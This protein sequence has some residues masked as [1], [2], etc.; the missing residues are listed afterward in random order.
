MIKAVFFDM[1]ETLLN[2]NL[3]QKKFEQYFKDDFALKYWFIKLLHTSTVT[4]I[5][6]EY[7]NF[8]VLADIVLENVFCE[9]GI[10]LSD[11]AKSEIL[12]SFR[13]LNTYGDVP[14]ALRKLRENQIKVITVSNSSLEMMKEQLTNAGILDLVDSYYS[15]DAVS[16]YKPFRDIYEF[17]ANEEKLLV[18]EVV[19]VATHDWDLF[20][21]K[22]SGLT[23]AYIKRKNVIYNPFYAQPDIAE[24]N[25]EIVATEILKLNV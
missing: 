12:N 11:E 22:K 16:K 25:L 18:S 1:N 17:V 21:A 13:N 15:V 6:D 3:L 8:G 9:A 7:K 10:P 2:L 5:M 20:G 4:G 19:M 24:E 23:T 14:G